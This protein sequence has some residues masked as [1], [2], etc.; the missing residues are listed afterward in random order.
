LAKSVEHYSGEARTR[1]GHLRDNARKR[2]DRQYPGCASDVVDNL[3]RVGEGIDDHRSVVLVVPH[4]VRLPLQRRAVPGTT[5]DR[6]GTRSRRVDQQ[7]PDAVDLARL[8]RIRLLFDRYRRLGSLEILWGCFQPLGLCNLGHLLSH[9]IARRRGRL[10][11]GRRNHVTRLA[12][13]GVSIAAVADVELLLSTGAWFVPVP[14][15]V[16][17][18]ANSSVAVGDA[19]LPVAV[20]APLVVPDADVVTTAEVSTLG[21]VGVSTND[22][23][24]VVV[25]AAAVVVTG[26]SVVVGAA[27][28]PRVRQIRRWC[29]RFVAIAGRLSRMG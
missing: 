21:A 10:G 5:V 26:S 20:A 2:R 11:I 13:A 22:G 29:H 6:V 14:D 25:G 17:E 28:T 24:S 4:P 18:G 16:V 1:L 9:H 15:V 3:E 27:A 23:V 8:R 19:E 12:R 7:V